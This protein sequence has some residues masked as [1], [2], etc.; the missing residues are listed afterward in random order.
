M[1]SV[2]QDFNQL[3]TQRVKEMRGIDAKIYHIDIYKTLTDIIRDPQK[4]GMSHIYSVGLAYLIL[5][6]LGGLTNVGVMVLV[7]VLI[8]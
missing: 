6:L 1:S 8:R 7:Q 3:V 4:F 2:A 5:K